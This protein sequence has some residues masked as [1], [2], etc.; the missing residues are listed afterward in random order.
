MTSY[1]KSTNFASKDSLPSGNT[2]K[3]IK[4]TEIDTE[5]NNIA[6]A[7]DTKADLNSPALVTPS[8][9][10]PTSGTLTS[11]TGL[12]VS[13]G[14]AGLGTGVATALAVN[15]GSSGAPVVNGGALGTPSSGT[16]TNV[17]GTA[18]SLTAGYAQRLATSNWAV[19][20]SGGY[21]YFQYGGVSKLRLD[22]SG[23]LVVSGNVTAY[24]SI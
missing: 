17:S 15:V 4:G 19:F 23:N 9:G 20:E 5:F 7:I 24:G 14:I 21:L 22:S 6:T 11:C 12:P 2:N 3:I 13:T 10:T 8:L 18:A 1:V 16:M